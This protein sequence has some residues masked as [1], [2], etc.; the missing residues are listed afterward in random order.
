MVSWILVSC[1]LGFSVFL[2]V[3]FQCFKERHQMFTSYVLGEI[4]LISKMFKIGFD[5][6][7]RLFSARLSKTLRVLDFQDFED[8]V[9]K[10][11]YGSKKTLRK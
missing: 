1:L 11:L 8:C 5:V 2:V 3:K 10:M 7:G 6:S 4:D 9:F